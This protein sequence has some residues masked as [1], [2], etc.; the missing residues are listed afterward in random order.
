MRT[1]HDLVELLKVAFRGDPQPQRKKVDCA[2]LISHCQREML[3]AAHDDGRFNDDHGGDV[4]RL[5]LCEDVVGLPGLQN[6]A[7][8]DDDLDDL[9]D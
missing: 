6:A 5:R 4:S 8:N 2:K 7:T 9:G 3:K 1:P